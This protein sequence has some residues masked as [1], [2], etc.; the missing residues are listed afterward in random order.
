MYLS[1]SP[2]IAV[3]TWEILFILDW[4][5]AKKAKGNKGLIA[6]FGNRISIVDVSNGRQKTLIFMAD[7]TAYLSSITPLTM[8]KRGCGTFSP[9]GLC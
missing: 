8:R 2:E 3:P 6:D 7:N 9:G 5:K 1:V 4:E